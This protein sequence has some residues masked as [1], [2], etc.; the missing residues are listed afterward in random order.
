M[1]QNYRIQMQ[2]PFNRSKDTNNSRENNNSIFFLR[3]E[4]ESFFNIIMFIHLRCDRYI[5]NIIFFK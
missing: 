1:S 3:K 4:R 5:K 2:F